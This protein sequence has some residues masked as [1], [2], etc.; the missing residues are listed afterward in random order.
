MGALQFHLSLPAF[1]KLL[2]TKW[3]YQYLLRRKLLLSVCV[4]SLVVFIFSNKVPNDRVRLILNKYDE[5]L[6]V[7]FFVKQNIFKGRIGGYLNGKRAGH[8]KRKRWTD[9]RK[10]EESWRQVFFSYGWIACYHASLLPVSFF[11]LSS[12]YRVCIYSCQL[13]PTCML[14]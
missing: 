2:F 7:E 11:N 4:H 3:K 12:K 8:G 9:K 14:A 13:K 6:Y 5:E 10:G 1:N